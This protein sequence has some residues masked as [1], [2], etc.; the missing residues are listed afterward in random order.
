MPGRRLKSAQGVQG[1]LGTVHEQTLAQLMA[2]S[3]I[4]A[5]PV[6]RSVTNLP[7]SNQKEEIHAASA[8]LFH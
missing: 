5:L 6:P 2:L 1:K 3:R 8:T 4:D 7:P